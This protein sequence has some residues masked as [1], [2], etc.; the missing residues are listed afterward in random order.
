MMVRKEVDDFYSYDNIHS[1]RIIEVEASDDVYHVLLILS[2]CRKER[3]IKI[4]AYTKI[5]RLL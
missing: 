2:I 4:G 5:Q 3:S 1:H